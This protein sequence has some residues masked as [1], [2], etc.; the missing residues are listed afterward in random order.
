MYNYNQNKGFKQLAKIQIYNIPDNEYF[1]Y[2]WLAIR[3][4]Y[5]ED[6]FY[7]SDGEKMIVVDLNTYKTVKTI[8]K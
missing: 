5:I 3:G 1:D 7:I 2:D 6:Y 8:N 4:L